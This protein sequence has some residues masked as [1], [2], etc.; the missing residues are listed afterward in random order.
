[1]KKFER[2]PA[3]SRR[4]EIRAAAIQL[5]LEKGFRATTMENIVAAVSLSKGGV[6]RIYS[7]TK[8][9]LADIILDGMRRRNTFYQERAQELTAKKASLELTDIVDVLCDAMLSSP[10]IAA[11]YTEF[12][13]EKRRIPELDALYQDICRQTIVETTALIERL[14]LTQQVAL[15]A[16]GMQKLTELMNTAILGIVVLD[17]HEDFSQY[18]KALFSAIIS[19]LG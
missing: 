19:V 7:S 14:G 1:M 15:D 9:I 6:Y 2:L 8:A 4:E 11:L 17:H 10:E 5:F 3:E 16:A 12:L 18:K 13:I